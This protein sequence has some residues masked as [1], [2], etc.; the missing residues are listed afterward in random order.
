MVRCERAIFDAFRKPDAGH[1]RSGLVVYLQFFGLRAEPFS[2]APDPAYLFMSERH[3]EALAHLLYAFQGSGAFVLLT[4]EVGTGKTTV[5]RA[6]LE[7]MPDN[8]DAALIVN[9]RLTAN[10]LLYAICDEFGLSVPRESEKGAKA[11]VDALNEY[12]ISEHASGRNPVLLIDEAQNLSI[13]A[14]EQLRLLTNLETNTRKLLQIILIG[15]PELREILSRTELR[16]LAQRITARYHIEPLSPGLVKAYVQHRLSAAGVDSPLFSEDCYPALYEYTRGIPR[17]INTICDRALLGAY[18]MRSNPVDVPIMQAAAKEVLGDL[19]GRRTTVGKVARDL[20]EGWFWPALTFA[21]ALAVLVGLVWLWPSISVQ[22]QMWV[23][24]APS[25]ERMQTP[26]AI[27][28]TVPAPTQ[29]TPPQIL[30]TPDLVDGDHPSVK[31]VVEVVPVEAAPQAVAAALQTVEMNDSLPWHQLDDLGASIATVARRWQVLNLPDTADPCEA[32][33]D[34]GLVCLRATGDLGLLRQLDRPV[35]LE[36]LAPDGQ[37][38]Y[39][40]MIELSATQAILQTETTRMALPHS[41]LRQL[42]FGDFV[43]LWRPPPGGARLLSARSTGSDVGWLRRQLA[44][45]QGRAVA[46]TSSRYDDVTVRAVRQ[47][48]REQGLNED[49]VAGAQTL[50]RLNSLTDPSIPRLLAEAPRAGSR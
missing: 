45:A 27:A 37:A 20:N 39:A 44:Q 22:W 9:P 38:H 13:S 36:L 35:V 6:L 32:L 2:I 49:G 31:A 48:Q 41:K 16:Q 19:P 1:H 25:N 33:A 30:P 10:E 15:Q 42:W 12:L 4:G 46:S 29:Q 24:G 21:A 47:F 26:V 7:Q 5:C 3:R 8:A 14:L 50:I 43:L 28:P 17:L 23:Q 40:S 11:P 34:F 18:G